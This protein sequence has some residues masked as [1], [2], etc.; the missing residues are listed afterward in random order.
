[1]II[2][3]FKMDKLLSNSSDTPTNTPPRRLM[4]YNPDTNLAVLEHKG[5]ALDVATHLLDPFPYKIKD[6]LQ[7]IGELE[8]N[9]EVNVFSTVTSCVCVS[10][11]MIHCSCPSQ[12]SYF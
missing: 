1:M 4:A 6:L 8:L 10:S 12:T 3:C 11:D 7:C 2:H 5:C 9:K